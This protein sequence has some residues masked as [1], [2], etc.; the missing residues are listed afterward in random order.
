MR[1]SHDLGELEWTLSG[2]T[3][4]VW[5]Q[6]RSI[7]SGVAPAADVPG[8]P[9]KVPGSVQGALRDAGIVP[10][11]NVGLNAR[12]CEWV[13]NRHWIYTARLPDAWFQG[14]DRCRLQA[15]GLDYKGWV[16]L[17]GAR[18]AEFE[19]SFVP[20]EIDLA[21]HLRP[22]ANTLQIVFDCPPRWLGQI[23]Y[24]SQMREWKPR[25]NYFWDWTSRLVQ[26]G[27]WDDVRI[28]TSDGEELGEI[29]CRTSLEMS[30]RIG[31]LRCWGTVAGENGVGI[32]VSL[33][34]QGAVVAERRLLRGANSGPAWS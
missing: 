14:G 28:E 19:G 27:I 2:W 29:D 21:P 24:T 26:A 25:F 16:L 30:T 32:Q 8:I 20:V 6:Q 15:L 3:P 12:E 9:A 4:Y 7:E 5:Q 13:E 10:D 18:I 1:T 23:G 31:S 17:N 33:Q 34:T 22:E 11:W